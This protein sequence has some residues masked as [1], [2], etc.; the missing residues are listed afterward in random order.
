MDIIIIGLFLLGAVIGFMKGFLK[1]L[2]SILGLVIGLLAAKMLYGTL[3]ERLC[4]TV[5]D[6]M[7]VAQVL[8]F[9]LI[10]L[11]VPLLFSL[12][13]SLLT[14]AMEAVSLGW[15][16]RWLGMGLG[17][18]RYLLLTSLLIGVIEFIDAD[19]KLISGTKKAD[20]V[21]YYSMKDFADIFLP[22]AKAV[23]EQIINGE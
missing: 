10:W 13:A 21:L 17:A 11:A 2:A 16:N 14:K 8:A 20:S 1:Q 4:D 15:L 12:A 19:N 6:S 3:A 5:T 18:L 7:T 9:V 23:T 22:V